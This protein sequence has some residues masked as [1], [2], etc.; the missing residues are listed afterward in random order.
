MNQFLIKRLSFGPLYPGADGDYPVNAERTGRIDHCRDTPKLCEAAGV[1]PGDVVIDVGG[2]IGDTAHA[3]AKAGARVVM[4]EPF[5]DS[6]TCALYN[7][8][9]LEVHCHNAPVGNGESVRL[10]YDCPGTNHGMRRVEIAEGDGTVEAVRLDRCMDPFIRQ[11][12]V[13]LIKIDCEG[14]EIPTLRGAAKLIAEDRPFLYVEHYVQGQLNCGFTP[15][16]LV[17][18]I[19]GLGYTLEMWGEPPRWDWLATPIK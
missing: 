14:F 8:H 7:T 5:I 13:K 18:T 4:F 17:E 16:E 10:V 12:T 3:F 11:H 6:F 2:F 1:Q 19:K 9:G 15:E